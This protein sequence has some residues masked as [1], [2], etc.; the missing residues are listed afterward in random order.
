MPV[1]TVLTATITGVL[2]NTSEFSQQFTI[3]PS[4]IV[5]APVTKDE[6]CLTADNGTVEWVATDAYSFSFDGGSTW[7]YQSDVYNDTLP[8]GSYTIDA[9]YLNGCIQSQNIVL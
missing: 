3:S 4:P 9:R 5:A 7:I 8:T 2:G 1:G 6:T